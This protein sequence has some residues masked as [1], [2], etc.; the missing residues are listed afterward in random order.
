[1]EGESER[2]V[3]ADEQKPKESEQERAEYESDDN[4]SE[5]SGYDEL[6]DLDCFGIEAIDRACLLLYPDQPNPIQAEAVVKFWLGGPHPLDYISMYSNEGDAEQGIPP[7]WHYITYGFTDLHGDDRVHSFTGRG[8]LSGFGF[9]LTFRLKK[10]EGETGPPM[11]PTTLLNKLAAYVFHTG[12]IL[13]VGDHIPWHQPLDG[14]KDSRIQHM[15]VAEEPQLLDLDTPYGTAQFRQIVGV[16]DE[17]VRSAQR[18]KGA[19][20]LELLQ[21]DPT[22]GPHFITDMQRSQSIF[23]RDPSLVQLVNEGIETDGSNLG[24]VTALCAWS[25]LQDDSAESSSKPG[26]ITGVEKDTEAK[27]DSQA[28]GDSFPA[29]GLDTQESGAKANAEAKPEG[30]VQT[31]MGNG[32]GELK[33]QTGGS[34]EV[35]KKGEEG[36]EEENVVTLDGIQL[37]FDIEAAE[38]IPL[39]IRGRLGKGR[40]FIFHNAD[41]QA[42][43]FVPPELVGQESVMVNSEEPI[44]CSDQYLQI[45]C[46]N[47]LMEEMVEQMDFVQDAEKKP[48]TEARV[49]QLKKLPI[50][51][52]VMPKGG[53]LESALL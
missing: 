51:I 29:T 37:L 8:A 10:A 35:E 53:P 19:G 28:G 22:V 27:S 48:F 6:N 43:H 40:F 30:E 50:L 15:L 25:M 11:W 18:W 36:E 24:H 26:Q 38:L 7:H 12:N 23:E 32:E 5:G 4:S 47:E 33:T 9:E 13:H 45:F 39:I 14:G 21:K 41:G 20:I 31:D 34:K 1:M 16:T 52:R 2:V 17:E 49:V 44:K 3:M 42:V 46:S